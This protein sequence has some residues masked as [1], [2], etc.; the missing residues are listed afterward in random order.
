MNIE[1]TIDRFENDKAVLKSDDGTTVTWPKSKLP[2]DM[3][4]GS[5][6]LFDIKENTNIE[7]ENRELAKNILNEILDIKE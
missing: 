4:E 2:K 7:E 6:C 1:F 5:I 3:I